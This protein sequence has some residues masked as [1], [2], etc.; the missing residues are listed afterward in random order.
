MDIHH[1]MNANRLKEYFNFS[2][3]ERNGIIVLLVMLAG[4]WFAPLLFTPD[5]TFDVKGFAR[6][7][8]TMIPVKCFT[9]HR[10]PS[11]TESL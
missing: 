1:D 8:T 2:K 6:Q 10:Q 11:H 7:K 3:K 4:V 9:T 5:E